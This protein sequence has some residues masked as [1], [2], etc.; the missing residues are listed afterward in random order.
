MLVFLDS[1]HQPD[2]EFFEPI[3]PL[4]VMCFSC[5]FISMFFFPFLTTILIWTNLLVIIFIVMYE[6]QLK[7]LQ[8]VWDKYER[9]PMNFSTFKFKF[10]PI[11]CQ[12]YRLVFKSVNIFIDICTINYPLVIELKYIRCCKFMSFQKKKFKLIFEKSNFFG[13]FVGCIVFGRWYFD[14]FL[15]TKICI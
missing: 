5:T 12:E 1:L 8:I 6:L 4:L 11:P 3:L 13:I 2:D 7:N 14:L 10:P 9:T 15:T